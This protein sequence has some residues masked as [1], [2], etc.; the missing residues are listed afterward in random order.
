MTVIVTASAAFGLTVLDAKT[1][2]MSLQTKGEGHVPFTVTAAGQVYK[3]TAEFVYLGGAISA[4]W[5][6]RSVEVTRRIQMAWACFGRYKMGM[7][8][9]PSVRLRLKVRILQ[10]EVLE[11]LQY[12]YSAWS[13]SKADYDRLRKVHHWML[14]GCPG[15]RKLKREDCILYAPRRTDSESVETTLRRRRILFAG[16]VARMGE[17]RLPRRVM[18]GEMLGSK[19]YSGGQKWDWMKDLEEDLKAFGITFEGWR[20]AAHKVGRWYRRVEDGAEVFMRKWHKDEKE[21]TAKR[22]RT[23]ATTTPT[24]SLIHI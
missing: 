6:L 2:I 19:G 10:A 24:L 15:W 7:Y 13:P 16:F 18:V 21:A 11:T 8:D 12:E 17:E 1:E 9:R 23:V 20:E 22:H 5:D 4:D 14:L 3:Q